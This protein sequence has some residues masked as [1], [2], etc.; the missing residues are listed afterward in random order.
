[1]QWFDSTK[2]F[3]SDNLVSNHLC[4]L[5]HACFPATPS[6]TLFSK[7]KPFKPPSMFV[8][9]AQQRPV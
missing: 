4:S 5:P 8:M 1:M 7:E 6:M 2:F 3:P 9:E